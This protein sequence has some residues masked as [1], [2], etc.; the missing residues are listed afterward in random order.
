MGEPVLQRECGAGDILVRD[1]E[2]NVGCADLLQ[3]LRHDG[4]REFRFIALTAQMAQV[5]VTKIAGHDFLGGVGSGGIGK[6]PVTSK[7]SLLETPRPTSA[8]LEQ[9]HIVIGLQHKHVRRAD[10]LRH[11][12]CHVTQVGEESN[13]RSIGAKKVSDGVLRVVGNREGFNLHIANV[14]TGPCGEQPAIDPD[15]E[16]ILNCVLGRS[17]AV[18]RNSELLGQD[19]QSLN[20]IDMFVGD[21]NAGEILGRPSDAGE[22]LTDLLRAESGIDKDAGFGRFDVG[23]ISPGTASENRQLNRHG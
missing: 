5:E 16:L 23:A 9:L 12:F 14:K 20:V 8:I 13:V 7:N 2:R 1:R 6:V 19:G 17:V 18:N 4:L 21:E 22:A 15:I 11:K 10:S 3:A